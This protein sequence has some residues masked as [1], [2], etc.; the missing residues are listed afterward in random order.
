MVPK[1]IRGKTECCGTS[2]NQVGSTKK[3][4]DE[5]GG[6]YTTKVRVLFYDCLQRGNPCLPNNHGFTS[7][8]CLSKSLDIEA[9]KLTSISE[10]KNYPRVMLFATKIHLARMV[11]KSPVAFKKSAK[12]PWQKHRGNL[13]K[14]SDGGQRAMKK[15]HAVC[16]SM[17]NPDTSEAE[18]LPVRCTRAHGGTTKVT[19]DR[20]LMQPKRSSRQ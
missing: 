1:S 3:V 7:S 8:R 16:F 15:Y 13:V 20:R 19:S 4:G 18:L 2:D 17:I 12:E 11:H 5:S 10:I 6:G 14:Y 9:R